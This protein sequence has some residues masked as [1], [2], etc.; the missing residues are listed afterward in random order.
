MSFLDIN[1]E[2]TDKKELI[3]QIRIKAEAHGI[4][5]T[6]EGSDYIIGTMRLAEQLN[7]CKRQLAIIRSYAVIG[8]WKITSHRKKIGWLI[9]L[10]KKMIRKLLRWLLKPYFEQVN[11]FNNNVVMALDNIVKLQEKIISKK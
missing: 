4:G 11:T 10:C 8:E 3:G 1:N 7:L 5:N 2:I 9:V 6:A